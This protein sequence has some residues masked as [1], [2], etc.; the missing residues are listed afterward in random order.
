MRCVGNL[1]WRRRLEIGAD[2]AAGQG[3]RDG[4]DEA[5]A[6][7]RDRFLDVAHALLREGLMVDG[8]LL[9]D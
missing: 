5:D 7:W 4:D 3:Q 8:M 6:P 9:A 2:G 1:R